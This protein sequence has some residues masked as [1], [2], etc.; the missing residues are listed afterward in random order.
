MYNAE[1]THAF[2]VV[3]A[4][5]GFMQDEAILQGTGDALTFRQNYSVEKQHE[6]PAGTSHSAMPAF[7]AMLES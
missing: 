7:A 6:G 3:V 4:H 5:M 1:N 2:Q